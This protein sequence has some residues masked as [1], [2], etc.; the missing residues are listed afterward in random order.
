MVVRF[1]LARPRPPA[2]RS[3]PRAPHPPGPSRSAA[4][5]TGP[6]PAVS[7]V[8]MAA[9]RCRPATRSSSTR[10]GGRRSAPWNPSPR[11]SPPQPTSAPSASD[12][13]PPPP[14]ACRTVS[15]PSTLGDVTQD[16]EPE[17][18]VSFR[19]PFRRTYINVTRPRRA[20]TDAPR[21]LRAPRPLSARRPLRDL[22]RRHA[23]PARHRRRRLRRRPR[24]GLWQ[25]RRTGYRRDQRLA[26][27]RL[28]LPARGTPPRT[29][30][31]HLRRYRWRRPDG[32]GHHGKERS[33]NR[34]KL[35]PPGLLIA[36]LAL[37]LCGARLRPW[38]RT[39][40]PAPRPP[41]YPPSTSASA[42]TS[43]SRCSAM[44]RRTP[45]RPRRPR[46]TGSP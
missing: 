20:W 15:R 14:G 17:L 10:P 23:G 28:R 30:H 46:S 38:P 22:G 25:A 8:P 34:T 42:T 7:V 1:P 36:C 37:S 27:G 32:T 26:L 33:V 45:D 19:R 2:A 44:T 39:R 12:S 43:S 4:T 24:R 21:P 5:R 40:P 31:P 16:G 18:V 41:S 11:H 35:V 9:G 29:R 13:P 6:T 3:L